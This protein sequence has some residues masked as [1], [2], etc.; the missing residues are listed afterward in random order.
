MVNAAHNKE[1]QRFIGVGCMMNTEQSIS[2]FK[3]KLGN[4]SL[5]EVQNGN[6]NGR[7]FAKCEWENPTGSIKDRVA[8]YMVESYLRDN[9]DDAENTHFLEY[10]GGSLGVS[11][12]WITNLLNL[13]LLLVLSESTSSST[14]KR[15]MELGADVHF[16]DKEKGFLGVINEAINISKH[17]AS[18]SFLYQHK[19]RANLMCHYNTTGE[20]LINQLPMNINAWVASIGTGGTLMGVYRRLK[21]THTDIELF[22]TNP[23]ELAYGDVAPPNSL[24]KFSGS[25]GLGYGQKQTFVEEQEDQIKKHFRVSYSECLACMHDFY[26]KEGMKI[27][28]S[29]AAN[30]IAARKI[31]RNKGKDYCT[32]TIFPSL[33]SPEEWRDVEQFVAS[34]LSASKLSEI[35]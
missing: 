14:I 10:T 31:A 24:K 18:L 7:I 15:V 4:T 34:K 12:A 13:P 25:G 35:I 16:V 5:L 2:T 32:A 6:N 17:N 33:A 21:E 29:A 28:T 9:Q 11:L 22:A 23:N 30:L 20:E 1:V 8:Y 26:V 19:N 27:G 3:S